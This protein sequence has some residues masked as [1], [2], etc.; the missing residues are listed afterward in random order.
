MALFS[1]SDLEASQMFLNREVDEQ[2]L[3]SIHLMEYYAAL[4]RNELLVPQQREWS[5]KAA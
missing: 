2:T 3:W 1:S 4:K 5:A